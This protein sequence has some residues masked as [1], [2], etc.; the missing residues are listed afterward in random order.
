MYPQFAVTKETVMPLDQRTVTAKRRAANRAA[1]KKSTGPKSDEGK[2]RA[3]FNS[4]Q[5]GAFASEDHIVQT[6][7]AQS[8]SEPAELDA[9]R[10]ELLDDWKPAGPQQ[11]LLVDDLAWLYWL[12]DQSRQALLDERARRPPRARLQRDQRRFQARHRTPALSNYDFIEDPCVDQE[13]SP[14]KLAWLTVFLDDLEQAAS[15]GRWKSEQHGAS[16]YVPR[17]VVDFLYGKD[18]TTMRGQT[19]REL[20]WDC[21]HD[22]AK[23]DD[24]RARRLLALL[25]EERAAVEEEGELLRRQ[26]ELDDQDDGA[27]AFGPLDETWQKLATGLERLDRQIN[28]KVRLLLRLQQRAA[29]EKDGAANSGGDGEPASSP[30]TQDATAGAY[31]A[32]SA[33]CA[34]QDCAGGDDVASD[35]VANSKIDGTKPSEPLESIAGSHGERFFSPWA[36]PPKRGTRD[37]LKA[38]FLEATNA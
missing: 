27:S 22:Q 28:A 23:G 16:G 26:Q 21:A 25:A 24:P 34:D 30:D 18:P 37:E 7:L 9:R 17:I 2:Q 4:F 11:K 38:E 10:Q 33:M 1:A 36:F 29:K 31:I 19:V 12:R 20:W 6:A 14:S 15:H 5:H 8:G 35:V 32:P 3:A 13:A